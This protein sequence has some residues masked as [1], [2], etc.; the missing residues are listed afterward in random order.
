MP[1]PFYTIAMRLVHAGRYGSGS[2]DP[3][4]VPSYI[5]HPTLVRGYDA[6]PLDAS[7]CPTLGIL[8][9]AITNPLIGSRVL[10]GNLEFRMPLFRPFTGVSR[11]MYG[12]LP[13]ELAVFADG[14]TAWNRGERP[15]SGVGRSPAA[16]AG[17]TLRA[18]VRGL[19]IAS[20]N[21]ARPFEGQ[22][23]GWVFQFTLAPGF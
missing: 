16:S 10:V 19:A 23:K 15:F 13:M 21:I 2:D 22:T 20:V 5:G 14:G 17:I 8:P 4:L 12:P 7:E 18:N 9:C 6:I 3:R 1:A 11:G